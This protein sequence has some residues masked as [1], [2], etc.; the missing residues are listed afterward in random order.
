[1]LWNFQGFSFLNA[2]SVFQSF[3]RLRPISNRTLV[4]LSFWV[5]LLSLCDTFLTNFFSLTTPK[6]SLLKFVGN[7]LSEKYCC[8]HLES[9]YAVN[10]S[11]CVTGK[12][13]ASDYTTSALNWFW[14]NL[15]CKFYNFKTKHHLWCK[16][17]CYPIW[18]DGST[19]LRKKPQHSFYSFC[20]NL[21]YKSN[22][23]EN[24][25][26][27]PLFNF[28]LNNCQYEF[29]NSTEMMSEGDMVYWM[30]SNSRSLVLDWKSRGTLW[31]DKWFWCWS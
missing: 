18:I 4:S 5:I 16:F 1:M 10:G 31:E 25:C 12:C 19:W 20:Y 3:S 29:L 15:F 7:G 6:S 23:L 2:A 21:L 13:N 30:Q 28:V 26:S 11:E 9:I 8:H 27:G 14:F 17:L 22:Q 24:T